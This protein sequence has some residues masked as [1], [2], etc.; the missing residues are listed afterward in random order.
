MSSVYYFK[1][2]MKRST[3]TV[4]AQNWEL[5]ATE[6]NVRKDIPGVDTVVCYSVICCMYVIE[7]CIVWQ[8][9]QLICT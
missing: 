2:S 4:L 5:I 1:Y 9:V 6:T 8:D 7:I 3:W